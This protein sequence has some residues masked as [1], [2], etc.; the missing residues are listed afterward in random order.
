MKGIVKVKCVIRRTIV[1]LD[2][3]CCKCVCYVS[4]VN[5]SSH[6][7]LGCGHQE[8]VTRRRRVYRSESLQDCADPGAGAA[9]GA[10]EGGLSGDAGYRGATMGAQVQDD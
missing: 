6:K 3:C 5:L 10:A 8:N 4:V 7:Q 1:V 2:V 9:G